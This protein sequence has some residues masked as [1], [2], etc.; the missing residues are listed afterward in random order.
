MYRRHKTTTATDANTATRRS[1]SQVAARVVPPSG[2]E[3]SHGAAEKSSS[4][5]ECT[6]FVA[7]PSSEPANSLPDGAGG[8]DP[9][10]ADLA[11]LV[12]ELRALKQ[13][14]LQTVLSH[15]D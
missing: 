3:R 11:R 8:V 2:L 12:A 14:D 7:T 1:I 13:S 6:D 10:P 9:L 15:L 4:S 5:D